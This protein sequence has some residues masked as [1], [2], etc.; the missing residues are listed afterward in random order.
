ML[1]LGFSA[2]PVWRGFQPTS[3]YPLYLIT[4]HARYRIC[5]ATKAIHY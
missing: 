2:V 1:F 4:P 5:K 3:E